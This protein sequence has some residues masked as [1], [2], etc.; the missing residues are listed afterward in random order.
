MHEY[1]QRERAPQITLMQWL[2]RELQ[3]VPTSL[4]KKKTEEIHGHLYEE[5]PFTISSYMIFRELTQNSLDHPMIIRWSSNDHAMIIQYFDSHPWKFDALNQAMPGSAQ[6]TATAGATSGRNGRNGREGNW[7]W[8]KISKWVG[9]MPWPLKMNQNH[10]FYRENMGKHDDFSGWNWDTPSS[11]GRRHTSHFSD[12][13]WE[14]I[15]WLSIC[16]ES[17]WRHMVGF[18][19]RWWF[20]LWDLP[21]GYD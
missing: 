12:Q 13:I 9:L 11:Y 2:G 21:S 7:C 17:E 3:R 5:N 6:G 14:V 20:G 18:F 10:H 16:A 4:R 15:F 8:K 1:R 19:G